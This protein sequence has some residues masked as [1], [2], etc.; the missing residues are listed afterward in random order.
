VAEGRGHAIS[1]LDRPEAG[2][3][4]TDV[5]SQGP[6][7]ASLDAAKQQL[8][9]VY[10]RQDEEIAKA[11]QSAFPAGGGRFPHPGRFTQNSKAVAGGASTPGPGVG[12][13]GYAGME[14][15]AASSLGNGLALV[16]LTLQRTFLASSSGGRGLPH[17]AVEDTSGMAE[18]TPGGSMHDAAANFGPERL[19]S[20]ESCAA[21]ARRHGA[22]ARLLQ[23]DGLGESCVW[24]K[25]RFVAAAHTVESTPNS[26]HDGSSWLSRRDSLE[27]MSDMVLPPPLLMSRATPRAVSGSAGPADA[28]PTMRRVLSE[29]DLGSSDS[30]HLSALWDAATGEQGEAEE[31]HDVTGMSELCELKIW[32]QGSVNQKQM[33]LAV[34]A[35]VDTAM[36]QLAAETYLSGPLNAARAMCS[37]MVEPTIQLWQSLAVR[38]PAQIDVIHR[39]FSPP[40]PAWL[41]GALVSNLTGDFATLY[42][43][44]GPESYVAQAWRVSGGASGVCRERKRIVPLT[45]HKKG[46]EE[47]SCKGWLGPENLVQGGLADRYVAMC[48]NAGPSDA[49][50]SKP[51]LVKGGGAGAGLVSGEATSDGRDAS[52]RAA[53]VDEG[54]SDATLY[55]PTLDHVLEE[56][57][58]W[59]N[60]TGG[61]AG[62]DDALVHE[63]DPVL[64]QARVILCRATAQVSAPVD[65]ERQSP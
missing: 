49:A 31:A 50:K 48:A 1:V 8:R 42:R 12:G 3:P 14:C 6:G 16:Q 51:V 34:L 35:A 20:V 25:A 22:A 65:I 10:G 61:S 53:G 29:N 28:P 18:E 43:H 46:A 63:T 37:Q 45:I 24:P 5:P 57:A 47:G 52:W 44:S 13:G 17:H 33:K 19:A 39:D 27:E 26:S 59:R 32:T 23:A 58:R 60:R 62:G 11:R 21:P 30:L 7:G 36:A 15:L 9:L 2:E 38:Q 56:L 4:A 55:I 64:P 54:S 41:L 40:M